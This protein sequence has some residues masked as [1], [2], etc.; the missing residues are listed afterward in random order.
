[1]K[2]Y[3]VPEM[4]IILLSNVDVITESTEMEEQDV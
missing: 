3:E 2:Q 4:E 1:M